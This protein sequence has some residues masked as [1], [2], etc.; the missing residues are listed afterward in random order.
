MERYE[1]ANLAQRICG[2]WDLPP[3]AERLRTWTDLLE[4][5]DHGRAG[6]TYAKSR[7]LDTMTPAVFAKQYKALAPTRSVPYQATAPSGNEISLAEHITLLRRAA[8]IGNQS[9]I[10]E[11]GRWHRAALGSKNGVV[12]I[13]PKAAAALLEQIDF[14]A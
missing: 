12:G 8:A 4:E 2:H 1:A 10:D 7:A 9:A 3:T 13:G 14:D 5:L 6:T 11:L